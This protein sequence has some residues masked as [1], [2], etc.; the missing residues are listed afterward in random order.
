[1][2]KGNQIKD[3]SSQ[4]LINKSIML[5]SSGNAFGEH[6]LSLSKNYDEE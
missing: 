1:M 3:K 2:R 5:R 6:G 4:S